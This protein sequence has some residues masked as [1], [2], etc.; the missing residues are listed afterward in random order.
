MKKLFLLLLISGLMLAGFTAQAQEQSESSPLDWEISVR[1]KQTAEEIER[2]RWL[3]VFTNDI[4]V[5]AF[6]QKSMAAD[7]E[8]DNLVHVLVKTTFVDNKLVEKLNQRYKSKLNS[9]DKV[10]YSEMQMIFQVKQ[11]MYAVTGTRVISEQGNVLEDTMQA[12]KFLPVP[13]ET[14]A[15]SMY[16]IVKAYKRDN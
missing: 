16:N 1:R 13:V 7:E 14:F 11:K 3:T 5:F 15:D 10:S 12:V 8:D 4:G 2:K 9:Y 6:D